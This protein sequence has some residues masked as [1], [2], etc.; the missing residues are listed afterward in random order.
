MRLIV[1]S[2]N[3][4]RR[5]GDG[6]SWSVCLVNSVIKS[7]GSYLQVRQS[8]AVL[9]ADSDRKKKMKESRDKEREILASNKPAHF[10]GGRPSFDLC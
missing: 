7:D 4:V 3:N 5:K 9:V 1:L 2:R 10:F 6:W 8:K